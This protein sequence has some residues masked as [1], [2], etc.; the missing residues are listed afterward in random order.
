MMADVESIWDLAHVET[1]RNSVRKFPLGTNA[2]L[3]VS[4][5][6]FASGPIPTAVRIVV[7]HGY[8]YFDSFSRHR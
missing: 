5:L 1:I 8:K 3:P 4:K 2:E 6:C 7:D